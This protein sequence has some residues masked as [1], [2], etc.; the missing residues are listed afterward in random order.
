MKKFLGVLSFIFIPFAGAAQLYHAGET[1]ADTPS[2]KSWEISVGWT[3]SNQ[4]VQDNG[5]ITV[6]NDTEGFTARGLYYPWRWLGLGVE[7]TW[8]NRKHFAGNN[9][10]KDTRYGLISKWILTPDTTPMAYLLVGAGA[11]EQKLDYFSLRQRTKH[12]WYAQGGVGVELEI[13]RGWFIGAEGLMMYH[14]KNIDALL[15][16][17]KRWE[18]VLT[19]RGGLRF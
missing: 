14:A 18:R 7:S 2:F 9:S 1:T 15:E 5:A 11:R 10:Y 17:G 19:I 3:H 16:Q 4:R 12:T 8:M 6:L 13:Y